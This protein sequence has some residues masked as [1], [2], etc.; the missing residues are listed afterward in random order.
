MNCYALLMLVLVCLI[1]S[2][3]VQ[4]EN[5]LTN[6]FFLVSYGAMSV[7]LVIGSKKDETINIDYT[8][9]VIMFF[10]VGFI[11]TQTLIEMFTNKFMETL[12]FKVAIIVALD[13]AAIGFIRAGHQI[14]KNTI[15]ISDGKYEIER[16]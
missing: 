4:G 5:L 15:I 8:L 6:A 2:V 7:V 11:S 13:Y 10:A 14:K 1:A 12:I 3:I 9:G 16:S